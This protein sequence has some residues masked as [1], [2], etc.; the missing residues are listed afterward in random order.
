M[1][2]IEPQLEHGHLA[3][4]TE[5]FALKD[6]DRF[7]EKFARLIADEP[8]S[9][10]AEIISRINDGVRYTFICEEDTYTLGVTEVCDSLT[11]AEFEPYERKNAWV[12]ETKPYQGVNSSWMDRQT[13]QLFEVQIHT[14][15]S[16]HA[17]QESHKAYEVIESLS[18][19][20]EERAEA[21]RLQ[22]RIFREVPIPPGI[23]DI[24][25]YRK[26]GW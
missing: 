13:E 16:W 10:P 26:E 6:P 20:S 2:R 3:E 18:S 15:A 9:D 11:A 7:K 12:D 25:P 24:L 14:P 22:E 4:D 21:A 5:K 19:T 1:R 23:T 8:D 17:K